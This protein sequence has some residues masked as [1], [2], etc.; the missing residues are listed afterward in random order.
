MRTR[1]LEA[2]SVSSLVNTENQM[3]LT[4]RFMHID[5]LN[6]RSKTQTNHEN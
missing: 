6:L 3:S 2:V 4:A 5:N 1:T